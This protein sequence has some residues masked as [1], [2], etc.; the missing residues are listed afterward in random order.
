MAFPK[1]YDQYEEVYVLYDDFQKLMLSKPIDMVVPILI[2]NETA[3]DFD[4]ESSIDK[5]TYNLVKLVV[6]DKQAA[7][8]GKRK[9][10]YAPM[11]PDEFAKSLCIN[12]LDGAVR[13]LTA[14]THRGVTTIK[15]KSCCG[16]DS[17][18]Q[19]PRMSPIQSA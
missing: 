18:P 14:L 11:S 19:S 4:Y 13:A 12:R 17:W 9:E 1:L 10:F 3:E 7:G 6:E 16:M 2:D 5:D 8:E 15:P